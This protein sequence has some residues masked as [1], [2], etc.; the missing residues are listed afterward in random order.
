MSGA[1]PP[2]FHMSNKGSQVQLC[3]CL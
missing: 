1:V 2:F 3:F